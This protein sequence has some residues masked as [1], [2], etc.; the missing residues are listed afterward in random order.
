MA[1]GSEHRAWSRCLTPR[2]GSATCW[3]CGPGQVGY[4]V[5][6]FSSSENSIIITLI[7]RIGKHVRGPGTVFTQQVLA[8]CVPPRGCSRSWGQGAVGEEV[9]LVPVHSHSHAHA[10]RAVHHSP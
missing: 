5:C 6:T 2:A 9:S 8:T 1:C 4:S 10:L 7:S 3:L